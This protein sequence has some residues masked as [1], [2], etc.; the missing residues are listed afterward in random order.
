MLGAGGD[1]V[2]VLATSNTSL[3]DKGVQGTLQIVS[4]NHLTALSIYGYIAPLLL[5]TPGVFSSGSI[6]Q[7]TTSV[8]PKVSQAALNKSVKLFASL[9]ADN[10][11]AQKASRASLKVQKAALKIKKAARPVLKVKKV[12]RVA[13]KVHRVSKAAIKVHV[14]V[15]SGLAANL[16]NLS[17]SLIGAIISSIGSVSN[18]GKIALPPSLQ[19]AINGIN[20]NSGKGSSSG[21]AARASPSHRHRLRSCQRPDPRRHRIRGQRA[22]EPHGFDPAGGQFVEVA[23]TPNQGATGSVVTSLIGHGYDS[24]LVGNSSLARVQGTLNIVNPGGQSTL[25]VDGSADSGK[26]NVTFSPGLI[27]GLAPA[28]ITYGLRDVSTIGLM[29]GTGG[30]TFRD[31]ETLTSSPV[32][33]DGGRGANSLIGP[34]EVNSWAITSR[35]AG[36]LG[37]V[38]F[39][40]AGGFTGSMVTFTRV[41]N[42]AGGSLADTFS[43]AN[44]ASLSGGVDGGGGVNAL[45]MSAQSRDLV[46]NLKDGNA[47]AIGG[48]VAHIANVVG[49][50]ANN[51]LVGDDNANTLQGGG[52]RNV[53]IGGGG[54]DKITGGKGDNVLIGGKTVA[55][56]GSAALAAVMTEFDRTDEDF[57]T[58]LAHLLSG[59]G[60]ND[61]TLLNPDTLSG[62]GAANV[63]TAGPGKNWFVAVAGKDVLS[64]KAL[65][66]GDVLTP[67][68]AR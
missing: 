34:D 17:P 19:G 1:A 67:I 7:A 47:T 64:P 35:D 61:P 51:V 29:G 31:V 5:V 42:L 52:G 9:L 62:D 24:V 16:A 10:T 22:R 28:D 32:T 68:A 49:G 23:G 66:A 57:L 27:R 20:G 8:A 65:K 39:T 25:V 18:V 43:L 38:S 50:R 11:K 41:G 36:T 37:K 15:K 12:A 3:A 58:R 53:L 59:D 13:L 4:P 54:L 60:Q 33:I 40:R 48:K 6:F 63:L 45:D 14:A 2:S 30:N 46:V 44:G 21:T 56:V 26:Q 55:D